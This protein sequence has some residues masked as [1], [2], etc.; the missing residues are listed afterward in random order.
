MRARD[1]EH[2]VPVAEID[3]QVLEGD[4][5]DRAAH[6]EAGDVGGGEVAHVVVEVAGV[7]GVELVGRVLRPAV[8]RQQR[9]DEVDDAVHVDE[10]VRVRR[11]LPET[12]EAADA[13][14]VVPCT[15]Q[16]RGRARDRPHGDP[17]VSARRADGRRTG[18]RV[19]DRD[20]VVP[21][22]DGHVHVL[23]A[24][25]DDVA[26][27]PARGHALL[28]GDGNVE[29]GH[30]Q[31]DRI[32]RGRER[33]LAAEVPLRLVAERE[34]R[35]A[36]GIR[37]LDPGAELILLVL[38]AAAL[39]RD[40]VALGVD[41]RRLVRVAAVR[42][43][44]VQDDVAVLVEDE[45]ALRVD[46]RVADEDRFVAEVVPRIAVLVDGRRLD[47]HV[48]DELRELRGIDPGQGD[49]LAVGRDRVAACIEREEPA[50]PEAEL[51]VDHGHEDDGA[52]RD[53]GVG[54]VQRRVGRHGQEL[55]V[56]DR[57]DLLLAVEDDRLAGEAEQARNRVPLLVE[58][59]FAAEVAL[60]VAGHVDHRVALVMEHRVTV[61]VQDRVPE[62]I[63]QRLPRVQVEH[64]LAARV[65]HGLPG[66][67]VDYRLAA[68]VDERIGIQVVDV[69]VAR[70][71]RDRVDVPVQDDSAV[72]VELVDDNLDC[73]D[74][75]ADVARVARVDD[76]EHIGSAGDGLL[77][78]EDLLERYN[79]RDV[80]LDQR[81]PATDDG[82]RAEAV[83]AVDVQ[84]AAVEEVG[85][86]RQMVVGADEN[87]VEGRVDVDLL[88]AR[89]LGRRDDHRDARQ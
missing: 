57:E 20:E 70:S 75:A 4:V 5:V 81:R 19:V 79:G 56:L 25:V 45:V 38:R 47:G 59:D 85:H 60:D 69:R 68:D 51:A 55:V 27:H 80:D 14:D 17:V 10:L 23:E 66:E 72:R 21:V 28:A 1:R 26:R 84:Q 83:V 53:L 58:R 32:G 46:D 15:G 43:A 36:R 82:R 78:V 3:V 40:G 52:G 71:A 34:D 61:V 11:R 41:D 6:V 44:G 86:V 24:R 2:V 65:L 8:D 18:V 74:R 76:V 13:H 16:D 30:R 48:D 77:L 49:R 39:V 88:P 63:E 87:L 64:R 35:V 37:V 9:R 31:L 54:E 42:R 12:G 7:V 50:L 22:A 33:L 29:V 73:V 62:R 89:G 67:R